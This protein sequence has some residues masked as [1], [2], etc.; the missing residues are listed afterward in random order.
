MLTT[1]TPPT[2]LNVIRGLTA[3]EQSENS[4]EALL[5][6][7]NFHQKSEETLP[8]L[9]LTQNGQSLRV[10]E[11]GESLEY[12][13][14]SSDSPL[15]TMMTTSLFMEASKFKARTPQQN[16]THDGN[17]TFSHNVVV[18]TKL[19]NWQDSNCL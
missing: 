1:P 3:L 7:A 14:E 16:F 4:Y 2:T 11:S 13:P 18:L 15:S 9:T 6:L 5:V 10:L 12:T 19:S 8:A 17:K